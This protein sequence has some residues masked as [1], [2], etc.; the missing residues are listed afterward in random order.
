MRTDR[1]RRGLLALT[2]IGALSVTVGL[3]SCGDDDDTSSD[4]S[5]ATIAVASTA[6]ASTATSASP[7]TT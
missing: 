1:P 2:A 3:A 6:E 5:P 7:T 4:T